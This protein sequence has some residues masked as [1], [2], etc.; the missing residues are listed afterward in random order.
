MRETKVQK[1]ARLEK[2]IEEQKKEMT[3]IKKDRKRLNYAVERLKREKKKALLTSTPYDIELI[4]EY[5]DE[6]QK[7][8]KLNEELHSVIQQ[9][10][11]QMAKE[12]ERYQ[13]LLSD[14]RKI[15]TD[16][17]AIRKEIWGDKEK[18]ERERMEVLAF[19]IAQNMD[20]VYSQSR[21]DKRQLKAFNT[22]KRYWCYLDDKEDEYEYP[23]F[24]C[25]MF[26]TNNLIIGIHP[27]KGRQ[28]S[29]LDISVI[30]HYLYA[31]YKTNSLYNKAMRELKAFKENNPNIADEELVEWA[32]HKG[33]ELLPLYRDMIL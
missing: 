14:Y 15:N 9:K 16:V 32:Y 4:C 30:Q 33:M 29:L 19:N 2:K 12:E 11:T 31:N 24:V 7:Q 22:E 23:A 20:G 26:A 10:E 5:S 27:D 6:L 17:D 13:R 28:L 1:I 25:P 3:E 18:F 21:D 8:Q